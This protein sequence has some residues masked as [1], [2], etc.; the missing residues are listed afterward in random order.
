MKLVDSKAKLP[1]TDKVTINLGLVDLAQMDLLVEEGFYTNRTDFVRT[2]IRNQL[3]R[4]QDAIRQTVVRKRFV[5]GMQRYAREEL[6]RVAAAGE[7]LEI[8]VL[9]LATIDDD[10][11]PE[12]A[13]RA[14]ASL[15]VLG[16]F[17]APAAVKA[18]LADRIHT[19]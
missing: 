8:H 17:L 2:A 3:Q 15:R 16:A 11:T 9:G 7:Q 14:I 19:T 18:A 5:M 1:D 10:V 4:H 13:R 6:E 12:L